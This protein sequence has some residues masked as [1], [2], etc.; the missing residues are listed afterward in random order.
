M[1]MI[2][3]IYSKA[4]INFYFSIRIDGII[5]YAKKINIH[6]KFYWNQEIQFA[7]ESMFIRLAIFFFSSAFFCFKSVFFLYLVDFMLM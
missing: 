2:L 3:W 4:K 7:S 1:M 6:F 5:Q